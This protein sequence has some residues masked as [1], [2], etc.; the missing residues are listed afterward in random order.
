MEQQSVEI[1]SG[2]YEVF[3]RGD[4]PAVLGVMAEEFE[5][6]EAEGIPHGG[7]YR[8]WEAVA[9]NVLGPLIEDIPNFE[10]TPEE[11]IASGDT[12]AAVVN[13]TGSGKTTGKQLD[14]PVVHVWDVR[15]GKIAPLPAVR[16][17]RE[18]PRGRG[19]RG[20]HIHMTRRLALEVR[21]GQL[22]RRAGRRHRIQPPYVP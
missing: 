10:A 14:L 16:G 19:G 11:F 17:H 8:N 9:Q 2:V 13:Y 12:V 20:S 4:L 22:L 5:W 6:Y 21:C 18:V 1:V 7:L 3:G 15:D